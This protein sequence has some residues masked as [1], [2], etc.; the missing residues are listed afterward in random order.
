MSRALCI[1]ATQTEVTAMCAKHKTPIS[2]IESLLPK[3]TRV[4]LLNG[5]DALVVAKA[6]AG[7][8]ITGA[9]TRTPIRPQVRSA[10]QRG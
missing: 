9:V 7:K 3:G 4:V 2:T 10:Q 5:H 8:I 6:Y 1:D